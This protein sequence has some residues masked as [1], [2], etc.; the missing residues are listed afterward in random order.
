MKHHSDSKAAAL[1]AAFPHTIPVM[2]GYIFLGTAFGILLGSKGYSFV[3]A[4]V[5][6]FGIY[7]G[8]M[9]FVSIG[10][11]TSPFDLASAVLLTLSVNARH[12]F[13]GL[14]MIEKFKKM[15]RMKPYMIFSLTDETYSLLCSVE[16]PEGVDE[17]R[18]YFFISLMNQFYW[19][20]GSAIG[21]IAGSVFQFDSTG[22]DFAMTAL[23]VVIFVEQWEKNKNHLPAMTGVI[24]GIACI[25]IFG[26]GKF[27]IP[28]MLVI[29][30]IL[31]FFR[32][33]MED[34]AGKKN[35]A[36]ADKKTEGHH[37]SYN[38]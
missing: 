31:S 28:A 6:S 8:S 7:A 17:R 2:L 11:L 27:I 5:M 9:Q 4:I 26:K 14:S 18:F 20:L 35:P 32:R 37:G 24:S 13:Y 30:L 23:F 38:D 12:I 21:G 29:F 19:V 34:S 16:A 22:I 33:Y 25:L 15:G 10:I 36:G 1:K 3:W